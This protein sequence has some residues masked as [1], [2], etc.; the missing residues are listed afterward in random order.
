MEHKHD[1]F[2]IIQILKSSIQ[3]HID[4]PVVWNAVLAGH[5]CENRTDELFR[6]VMSTLQHLTIVE[7]PQKL[8]FDIVFRL[9]AELDR[10]ESSKIIEIVEFCLDSIRSGDAKF[11][12]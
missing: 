1:I 4:G 9:L 12:G 3:H 11:V 7:V 10:F 6:V 2:Q 8:A 5:A